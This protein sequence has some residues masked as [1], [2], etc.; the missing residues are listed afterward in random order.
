MSTQEIGALI[1]SVNDMTQTVANKNAEIDKKVDDSIQEMRNFIDEANIIDRDYRVNTATP[2]KILNANGGPIGYGAYL[3][4]AKV[5]GTGTGNTT[6]MYAVDIWNNYSGN[7]QVVFTV[8]KAP[9]DTNSNH[10]EVFVDT[11]GDFAIRLY[12]HAQ[13]YTVSTKIIG[14]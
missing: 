5:D 10:I 9:G 1:D 6:V 7:K 13:L 3:F 14:V 8:I 4:M 12:N 11:D 2:S